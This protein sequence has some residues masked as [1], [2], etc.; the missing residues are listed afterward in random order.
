MI[1]HFDPNILDKIKGKYIVIDTNVL[2]DCSS[3]V[4]F[5]EVFF[6]IFKNNPLFIDP[7]VKLEFLRGAYAEKT[8]IEKNELL[9]LEKFLSMVD[10]QNI[11][12]KIYDITFDIARIYSHKGRPHVPLGDILITARLFVQGEYLFLTEDKEDFNTL[13][14]DRLG[15]ISF[16]R[17][18]NKDKHEYLQHLQLLKINKEKYKKCLEELPQ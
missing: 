9:K 3:D 5:Y 7:I 8:Y 1:T 13:M 2:S 10:H 18:N 14:F 6:D 11:Y 15:V 16:E 12:K 17:T 4:E